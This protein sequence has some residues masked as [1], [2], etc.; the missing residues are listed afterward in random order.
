MQEVRSSSKATT[1]KRK[2]TTKKRTKTPTVEN[3]AKGDRNKLKVIEP[4]YAQIDREKQEVRDF[5]DNDL[6][7]WEPGVF[8]KHL[9]TFSRYF[10]KGG[11]KGGLSD[12]CESF[13]CITCSRYGTVSHINSQKHR[14]RLELSHWYQ[15]PWVG[16]ERPK[17]RDV[18]A[19]QA[20]QKE[21]LERADEQYE[22]GKQERQRENKARRRSV[23]KEVQKFTQQG[24]ANGQDI[25]T[26]PLGFD[27]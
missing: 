25:R 1:K 4:P 15:V 18:E 14:S 11:L 24:K 27:L 5:Y 9:Q 21:K 6:V 20:H 8:E 23:N 12:A 7:T 2:M 17:P 13:H 3:K 26:D 16:G 22:R 19:R 10:K